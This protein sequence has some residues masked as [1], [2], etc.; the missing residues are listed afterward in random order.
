MKRIVV[1][2]AG[3][4]R[5]CDI[6]LNGS[7]C[8]VAR[9]AAAIMGMRGFILAL[10]ICQ[11]IVGFSIGPS[12]AAEFVCL[13]EFDSDFQM[14]TEPGQRA[15]VLEQYPSGRLPEKHTCRTALIKGPIVLGDQAKL[16]DLVGQNHP[17]LDRVLLWSSG[18]LVEEALSMSR[19]IRKGLIKTE[20]PTN[21]SGGPDGRLSHPNSNEICSGSLCHC[22]GACFLIWASGIE[23]SGNALGIH[24]PTTTSTSFANLPPDRASA[25]YRQLMLNV[26]RHLRDLEIP[27]RFIDLMSENASRDMH[28]L[29]NEDADS[30]S[31]AP[32]VAEW[33]AATCGAMSA[34]ERDNWRS[35][36]AKLNSQ[37]RVTQQE[38]SLYDRLDDK[39]YWV[40][41][42]KW[43]RIDKARHSVKVDFLQ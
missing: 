43:D 3:Y 22:A 4:G 34:P 37:E 23:R 42:C 24:R 26:V 31:V 7:P 8:F 36:G 14:P 18:G 10:T 12:N 41:S 39:K 35:I 38:R 33:I 27:Q 32:S 5:C 15:K 21:A 1:W 17:F 29:S 16:Y 40:D 19:L 11:A 20:A 30:I 25:Q 9:L 6:S 28:W 2:L 13:D